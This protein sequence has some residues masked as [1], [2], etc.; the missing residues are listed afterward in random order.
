MLHHDSASLNSHILETIDSSNSSV[1]V[2]GDFFSLQAALLAQELRIGQD[3]AQRL[4]N[5]R[6]YDGL[7]PFFQRV[8]LFT[9]ARE[10]IQAF[11]A[12]GLKIALMSDFPPEQK[13]DVWGIA[14]LCDAVLSS[15]KTG[16][17]KPKSTP[18]EALAAALCVE[19]R[20]ILYV[21]NSLRY[22]VRGARGAGFKT[23]YLLPFWRR[24][25]SKPH[26]EADFSFKDY[27][28]LRKIVLE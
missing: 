17:L 1:N 16:A 5:E 6:V 19:P 15:E 7:K 22:D 18:F 2:P 14:P 8:K 26:K 11:K 25:L 21:G 10:T 12:A 13:G 9:G 3:E 27:R 23:A 28:Q 24:I 20:H 4:L